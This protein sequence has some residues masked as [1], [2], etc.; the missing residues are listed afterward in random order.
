MRH[1]PRLAALLL[2]LAAATG[3]GGQSQSNDT[4]S[5]DDI[6]ARAERALQADDE[7]AR[8]WY[9]G[10]SLAEQWP[11]RL[12]RSLLEVLGPPG[13]RDPDRGIDELERMAGEK[14]PD[15]RLEPAARSALEVIAALA[16]RQ[17][18]ASRDRQRLAHALDTERAAHLRTLEK[19]AAL[20]EIDEELDAREREADGGE[21]R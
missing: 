11:A 1:I 19:L 15:Y 4:I 5:A 13:V 12:E 16:R 6:L 14:A 7:H 18:A 20:R 10:L 21:P 17:L 2:L 8:L 3:A 9:A